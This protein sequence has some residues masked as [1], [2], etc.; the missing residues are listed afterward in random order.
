MYIFP[1]GPKFE[2][3]IFGVIFGSAK[4][5]PLPAFYYRYVGM[6]FALKGLFV[7]IKPSWK[8]QLVFLGN[9]QCI[10]PSPDA[11]F[12]VVSSWQFLGP[13]GIFRKS[14]PGT[15]KT[16]SNLERVSTGN[17]VKLRKPADAVFTLSLVCA[18]E[19]RCFFFVW[20]KWCQFLVACL[21]LGCW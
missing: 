5:P 21:N 2:I 11:R 12:L 4:T 10:H 8:T 17:P 20:S 18:G 6:F 7:F 16:I 1:L 3:V 15:P 9:Q 13:P 14:H 19:G